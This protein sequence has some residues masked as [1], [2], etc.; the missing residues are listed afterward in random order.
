MLRCCNEDDVGWKQ[1]MEIF[2]TPHQTSWVIV[3]KAIGGFL[4]REAHIV[5]TI[6]KKNLPHDC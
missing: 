4:D 2:V 3:D 6:I 1:Q 5:V